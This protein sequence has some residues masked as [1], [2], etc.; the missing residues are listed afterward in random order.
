MCDKNVHELKRIIQPVALC[1][2]KKQE[3]YDK[4][5]HVL[6]RIMPAVALLHCVLNKV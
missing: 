4:N 2:K 6:K 5:V 3:R 1:A